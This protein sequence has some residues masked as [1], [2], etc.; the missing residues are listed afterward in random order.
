M[1]VL[2]TS[3]CTIHR[4]MYIGHAVAT[5]VRVRPASLDLG[6]H[7]GTDAIRAILVRG[8]LLIEKIGDQVKRGLGPMVNITKEESIMAMAR[9]TV[10]GSQGGTER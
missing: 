5:A 2:L 9:R 7:P 4:M 8:P 6:M 3:N 1:K 10:V